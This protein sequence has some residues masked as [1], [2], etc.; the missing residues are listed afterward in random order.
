MESPSPPT[1]PP[2]WGVFSERKEI[3]M[4]LKLKVHFA[5]P[6]IHPRLRYLLILRSCLFFPFSLSKLS[7][8]KT[9]PEPLNLNFIQPPPLPTSILGELNKN[10]SKYRLSIVK[11]K[12]L[13]TLLK[14]SKEYWYSHPGFIFYP[15]II[16]GNF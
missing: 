8:P 5:I 4:E 12:R 2:F 11:K 15:F 3:K 13:L 1:P 6:T 10:V 9:M 16:R 7:L 14:D